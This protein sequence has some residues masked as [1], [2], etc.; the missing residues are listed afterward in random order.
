MIWVLAGIEF[1]VTVGGALMDNINESRPFFFHAMLI[2][3]CK[4]TRPFSQC[5]WRCQCLRTFRVSVPNPTTFNNI[6]VILL[7]FAYVFCNNSY[8]N[9]I[10]KG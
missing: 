7:A 5:L 1:L 3:E 4:G 6:Q 9:Y 8:E 2:L 10:G